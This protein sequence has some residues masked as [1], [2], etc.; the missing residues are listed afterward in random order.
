[1]YRF[2]DQNWNCG[3]SGNVIRLAIKWAGTLPLKQCDQKEFFDKM[4]EKINT[5]L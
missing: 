4:T 2:F 3:F 5:K 1:M